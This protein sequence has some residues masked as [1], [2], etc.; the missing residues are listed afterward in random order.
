VYFHTPAAIMRERE[1][2]G[3]KHIHAVHTAVCSYISR[4]RVQ[5]QFYYGTNNETVRNIVQLLTALGE[6]RKQKILR[7]V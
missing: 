7:R 5:M 3:G 4:T 1:G 2:G 6:E